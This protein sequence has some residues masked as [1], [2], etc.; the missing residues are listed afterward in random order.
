MS[1]TREF[2][3]TIMPRL[4]AA[5]YVLRSTTIFRREDG[6]WRIVHRHADPV[7]DTADSMGRLAASD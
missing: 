1:D 7:T 5:P 4:Q 3:A 2:L 6:D